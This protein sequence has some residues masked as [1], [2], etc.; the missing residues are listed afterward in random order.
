MELIMPEDRK[1]LYFE[2][3]WLAR[4]DIL[5]KNYNTVVDAL[6]EAEDSLED[7]LKLIYGP[8]PVEGAMPHIDKNAGVPQRF[9]RAIQIARLIGDISKITSEDNARSKTDERN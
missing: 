4:L 9:E 1:P 5:R 7:F 3:F 2:E 8:N 6:G